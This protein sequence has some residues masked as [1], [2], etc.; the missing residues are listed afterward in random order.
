MG[1]L[2][3]KVLGITLATFLVF[4]SGYYCGVINKGENGK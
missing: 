1:I 3:L 2:I 4:F